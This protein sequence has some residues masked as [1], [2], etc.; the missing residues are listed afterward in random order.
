MNL[1]CGVVRDLLPLYTEEMTCPEST[2][3]V[4]EHLDGCADCREYLETLRQPTAP[5][6]ESAA[7]IKQ[8][9]SE[10]RR[11]RLRAAAIAAL[12]VFVVLFAAL[13]RAADK[14]PLEYDPALLR[15]EGTGTYDPADPSFSSSVSSF[16]P[17][18]WQTDWP[19][20]ALIINENPRIYGVS[21]E[22]FLDGE[23]GELTVYIQFYRSRASL[24]FDKEDLFSGE[25]PENG[26]VRSV[27]YPVPDRVVY[28]FG[29]EQTL[30]WGEPMNGGVQILPRLA[31]AYYAYLAAGL[32]VILAILWIIFRRMRGGAVLLQ[33]LFAPAS[34][35]LGQLFVKGTRTVSEFLPRDFGM[36]LAEAAAFYALLTLCRLVLDRKKKDRE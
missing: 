8:L 14:E 29:R 21:Y 12:S 19:G 2:E 16:Q 4:R 22:W 35:L 24:F 36:I 26:A 7:P 11:R 34:Y 5:A 32:A 13:A 23:K 30:L 20:Q 31:L 10:L 17:D 27:L 25:F 15:V 18:E 33:L 1:P 6:P 3:L 9:K 28:G